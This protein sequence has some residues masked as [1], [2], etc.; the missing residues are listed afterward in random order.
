MNSRSFHKILAKVLEAQKNGTGAVV[1]TVVAGPAQNVSLGS[2]MFVSEGEVVGGIHASLDTVLVTDCA[3][4]LR[5]KQSRVRSYQLRDGP[6]YV[7]TQ[8]GEVD[9]F[10]EVLSRPSK[11]VIVG[12]GHIAVPL[13]AMAKLLDFHV[14]VLDDRPDFLTPER[15]PTADQL[16]AGPY[17]ETLAGVQ[18][19][20][21]THVVLVT[22]G[23]V[24]DQACLEQ[25]IDSPAAYIGMIG[26]N[27]RVRTVMGHAKERGYDV[28]KLKRVYAPIGLDIG[29]QTPAEIGLAIMAEI[30]NVH[31]GGK[32]TSLALHERLRV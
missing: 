15:F 22:R 25:V 1:L 6:R 8:G 5:N 28:G 29:S 20:S 31:R 32:G 30:V 2:R 17:R 23:H 14:L 18:M 21:D 11:L 26:S 24:H 3:D 10:F 27:L 13:A 12:A 16:L 7:G 4:A 19:D 9:V